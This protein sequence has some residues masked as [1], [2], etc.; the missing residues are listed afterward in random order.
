MIQFYL[1]TLIFSIP[2]ISYIFLFLCSTSFPLVIK[3][4]TGSFLNRPIHCW[5]TFFCSVRPSVILSLIHLA[6]YENL[7]ANIAKVI[8]DNLV[9]VVRSMINYIKESL[10]GILKSAK[11]E[12]SPCYR[13]QNK[14]IL[15]LYCQK[16]VYVD[17]IYEKCSHNDNIVE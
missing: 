5:L 16:D 10:T 12:E 14:R 6:S 9:L 1:V 13:I 2:V 3:M 8:I 4:P 11:E 7:S 15:V 17:M